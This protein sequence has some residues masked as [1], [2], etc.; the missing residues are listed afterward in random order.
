MI[1]TISREYGAGGSEIARRVAGA[2]GWRLVDND[3]IDQVA[4]ESGLPAEEVARKEERAPGFL[5][6][7]TRA[8][9][10]AA[11]ELFPRPTERV[12]EPEEAALVRATEKAVAELARG[13]HVVVVGRAAPAVLSHRD[14]LHVRVIAPKPARVARAM[15]RLGTDRDQALRVLEDNDAARGRYHRQYYG[16]DWSDPASYHM[17]LN[18]EA[19]G[20]EGTARLIEAE[21]RLR[22]RAARG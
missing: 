17:V 8:L 12:P 15:E 6:R 20:I 16:R 11:P 4:V 19:L 14:A 18:T 1:V 2:L 7:L 22:A 10:R 9:A 3:V 5:E 21:V 13:D